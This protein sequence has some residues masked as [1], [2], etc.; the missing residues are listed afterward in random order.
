MNVSL[1]FGY[2]LIR[3]VPKFRLGTHSWKR[4]FTNQILRGANANSFISLT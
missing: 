1:S 3:L 4:R 2:L